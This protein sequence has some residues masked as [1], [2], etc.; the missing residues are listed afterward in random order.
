MH[1][2][3]YIIL[4]FGTLL[5]V[6][7]SRSGA[8]IAEMERA[9]ALM[10]SLPDSALAVMRDIDHRSLHGS[11]ARALYALTMSRALDRNDIH[12]ASD[13]IIAPAVGHYRPD[14]DPLRHTMT[15][16]YLG[17]TLF[18]TGDYGN[19]II[20][21][22]EGLETAKNDSLFFWAGMNARG[23]MQNFNR[24]YNGG[25][26][27]EY[28]GISYDYFS[29]TEKKIHRIYALLDKGLALLNNNRQDESMPIFELVAEEG[30]MMGDSALWRESMSCIVSNAYDL[31]EYRKCISTARRLVDAGMAVLDDSVYMAAGYTGLGQL[32]SA[33]HINE[34]LYGRVAEC[35]NFLQYI[36]YKSENNTQRALEAMLEINAENFQ[37]FYKRNTNDLSIGEVEYYNSL[38][39]LKSERIKSAKILLWGFFVSL[40]LCVGIIVMLF[41]YHRNRLIRQ[42]EQYMLVAEELKQSNI[43]IESNKKKSKDAIYTL[44]KSHYSILDECCKG[45]VD[46]P[47]KTD[48]YKRIYETVSQLIESFANDNEGFKEAEQIAIKYYGNTITN[49]KDIISGISVKEYQ[50]FIFSSLGF[51]SAAIALFMGESKI[52]NIYNHRRHLKDKINHLEPTLAEQYL[53]ILQ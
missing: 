22:L 33:K 23:V 37:K 8:A 15:Q 20:A 36:I 9:E 24:T 1:R 32:D 47:Q 6:S 49:I 7:C 42:R 27:L 35:S 28:A 53:K 4:L 45:Y 25:H 21:Y 3:L 14:R 41:I 5:P 46:N 16:Y 10:D 19:S 12:V 30:L 34:S 39:A 40:I 13:S 50:L 26:E 17:R 38:Q 11:E 48:N 44:L 52:S 51:S 2:F 31:G 29:K 18:H 43:I